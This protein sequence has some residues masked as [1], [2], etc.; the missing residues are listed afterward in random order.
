VD[1]LDRDAGRER[2]LRPSRR[3]EEDEGRPQPLAARRERLVPDSGY[4]PGMGGDGSRK[5][6][7]ERVEVVVESRYRADIG[8]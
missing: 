3:R 5:P 4:E 2:G 6:L 1:E 7:L 8:K